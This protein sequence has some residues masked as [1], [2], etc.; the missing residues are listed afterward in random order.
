[1][2][3]AMALPGPL[4]GFQLGGPE[5][6]L[7]PR[8]LKPEERAIDQDVFWEI[9]SPEESSLSSQMSAGILVRRVLI[10]DPSLT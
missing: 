5:T 9:E 3:P 2:L 1:M 10:D 7:A 8:R 4:L 6:T